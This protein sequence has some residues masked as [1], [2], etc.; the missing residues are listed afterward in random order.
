MVSVSML[1]WK[2]IVLWE[3]SEERCL[4]NQCFSQDFVERLTWFGLVVTGGC[5]CKHLQN[6]LSVGSYTYV[7]PRFLTSC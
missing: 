6:P 3:V 4:L 5:I 7:V 1:K 2:F